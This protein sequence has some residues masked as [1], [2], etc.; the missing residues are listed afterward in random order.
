MS[1]S[2]GGSLAF[3]RIRSETDDSESTRS[4]FDIVTY[5]ADYTLETLFQLWTNEEIRIP[6]FQRQF[7][8]KKPQSSKL[9]ESFMMGLPVPEIFLYT[10]KQQRFIVIDGQ[11]RLRSVFYFFEGLFE[12]DTLGRRKPFDLEG[13]SG[14][15]RWAGKTYEQFDDSDKR[16]L[17]NCILRAVIVKQLRPNDNTSIY[18]IFERLNTGGT[19][20]K[21]QEVRNCVYE[22][23]L[24]DLLVELNKY[25]PWRDLLGHRNVDKHQKDVELILR[26]MSL[27]HDGTRYFKPM[28]DFMS[29]FMGRNMNPNEGFLS[30]E[31]TR[32][33]KTCDVIYQKLGPRPFNPLG[34]LNVAVF[35]SLFLAFAFHQG[36]IP[37]D[38]KERRTKLLANPEYNLATHSGTTDAKVVAKRIELAAA[39]LFT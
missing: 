26:Y 8:W 25:P 15:S 37:R 20:L 5:P 24:N 16:K 34:P 3:E 32:F 13:L 36:S 28:K 23:A 10:D 7:V 4:D 30:E 12:P 39:M 31:R 35:D 19:L 21:D 6:K 22:G 2:N 9:V 11:Q 29:E 14:N 27:Y 38:I 1:Q 18:H 17:R 33:N